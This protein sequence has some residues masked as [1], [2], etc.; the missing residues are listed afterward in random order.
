MVNYREAVVTGKRSLVFLEVT[1]RQLRVKHTINLSFDDYGLTYSKDK[2]IVT[3]TKTIHALD[4]QDTEQW[5]VGQYLLKNA[6]YVCSNSDGRRIVDT[7]YSKK[8][9]SILDASSG[10]VITYR[11]VENVALN[12]GPYGVSVDI[13][14]NIFVCARP[15]ILFLSGDTKKEHVLF[16]QG[17]NSPLAIAY[18]ET[19]RQLTITHVVGGDSVSC[20][21]LP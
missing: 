1:D 8:I 15:N 19:K 20:L 18:D 4:L 10:A 14:D 11:Q 7:D 5:S 3:D 9:I 21:Q 17:Y 16:N 13:S 6:G 12:Y 2:L